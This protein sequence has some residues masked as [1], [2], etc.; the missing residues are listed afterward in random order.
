VI[1]R[2]E[3]DLEKGGRNLKRTG[4][5]LV[6][7]LLI[8]ICSAQNNSTMYKDN[9]I[10]FKIPQNWSVSNVEQ[11][12]SIQFDGIINDLKITLS[13]G[14]SSI[15]I[16]IVEIPQTKWLM[17]MY[18]DV[19]QHVTGLLESFY[20]NNIFK[21]DRKGE[22]ITEGGYS[23]YTLKPDDA[24]TTTF[25]YDSNGTKWSIAWIKPEYEN[26]FIGVHA[27]YQGLNEEKLIGISSGGNRTM[28]ESL[29]II[30]DS[31]DMSK[32]S[33]A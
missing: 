29:Y 22:Q 20:L 28:P 17:E 2:G 26:K 10:S 25:R 31:I 13:D 18:N 6:F 8:S 5:V 33:E 14:S 19:P 21:L 27:D 15:G 23:G 1:N 3:S 32:T 11:L 16:D 4:L 7:M 9:G 24:R 12:K 30:L